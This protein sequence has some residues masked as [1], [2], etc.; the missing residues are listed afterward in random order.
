MPTVV[1]AWFATN[2]LA[3]RIGMVVMGWHHPCPCLGSFT[4]VIHLSATAAD[5]L[6]KIV[7]AYLLIGSYVALGWNWCQHKKTKV[8]I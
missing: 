6:M 4:G 8:Q 3:Y 7:L 2:L 5:K 1:V